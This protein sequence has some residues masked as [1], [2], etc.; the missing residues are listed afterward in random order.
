MG[1]QT[2]SLALYRVAR[3]LLF[4]FDPERI[5]RLT[6]RG[7]QGAGEDP[8]GRSILAFAGAAPRSRSR[9]SVAGLTLRNRIGLA[10]GFDKN[11]VA[12]RGWAALG[13]GFAEVGTV[14]PLPQPG[15]VRPR[16]FR[17]EPDGGLINRMGFNNAGAAELA[18]H[19]M[20]ARRHLP[21]GFA[22]GVNI[23]R[24]KETPSEH[25]VDDYT[26]SFR[27]VA[28]V[29]DYVVVN[30][31]S[32]NTPGLRDLQVPATLGALLAG[33]GEAGRRLALTRPIFVKLA[34]DLDEPTVAV[35]ASVSIEHG[36]AGLILANTTVS[37]L[38]LETPPPL[39]DEE[40]GLSG[41]ALLPRT[42]G[43]VAAVRRQVGSR[44]AIV[45]S[46]GIESGADAEAA[47]AAG[48]DLVQLWTG[49]VYRGPGLIGEAIRATA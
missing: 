13:F 9:V 24:G 12:L 22:V 29:A 3:P 17:L 7:L 21:P 47:L 30:V 49:L 14:T 27:L 19:V 39:C 34:P 33:L 40:G 43:L 31:S 41:R 25:A 16:L 36:A 15:N 5:H 8:V 23:G 11:G 1:R 45:A 18:R 46:G 32:P 38:G 37:R 20:L 26:A 2:I 10:A 48:A 35:L 4:R 42:L 44:L 6:M 28:P